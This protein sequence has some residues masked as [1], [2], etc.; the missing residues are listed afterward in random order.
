M[1]GKICGMNSSV[2]QQEGNK[3]WF[4]MRDLTR[5][6]AK[7]PAYKML[8]EK[9]IKFFTPMELKIIVRNGI[10]KR[11]KVPFMHDLIFVFDTREV[12]DPI[13]A[14]IDTFQYRYLRHTNRIP[15]TVRREDMERFICAVESVESPHYHTMEEITPEMHKRKI[16]IIGGRLD[17]FEGYLLTVRG[18]KVKRLLVELPTLLAAS[19]E[20]ESEYIQLI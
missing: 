4:V 7:L 18:S 20:V 19:V 17:G 15:M 10:R 6:N 2:T 11:E 5:S 3:Q 1:I 13:V 8:K 9:N 16:R 14:R 12:L